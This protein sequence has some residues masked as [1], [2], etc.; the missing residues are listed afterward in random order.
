MS[1]IRAPQLNFYSSSNGA[2]NEALGAV[3]KDH[4]FWSYWKRVGTSTVMWPF[5]S[6]SRFLGLI[7]CTVWMSVNFVFLMELIL[8]WHKV[9]CKVMPSLAMSDQDWLTSSHRLT[10]TLESIIWI[11]TVYYPLCIIWITCMHRCFLMASNCLVFA[12]ISV[13]CVCLWCASDIEY[14]LVE[15][16]IGLDLDF[17]TETNNIVTSE[18]VLFFYAPDHKH[19]AGDWTFSSDYLWSC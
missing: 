4:T 1:L 12:T 11:I 10:L 8:E 15:P 6:S 5:F 13:N 14:L 19:V 7:T 16:L 18:D 3:S 2:L 17:L 9:T